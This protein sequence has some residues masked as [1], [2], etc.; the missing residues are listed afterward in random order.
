MKSRGLTDG[1][2][3]DILHS[4]ETDSMD[5][6]RTR[7]DTEERI[8]LHRGFWERRRL[9]HPPASFK[10]GDFFFARHYS[11]ARPLLV[12]NRPVEPDMLR[13][14]A[15]LPD[16]E[17]MYREVER[18][19]QDGF[20][21]AEPY[22]G[23]PWMEAVLGCPIIAGE[24]SFTSKPI[25]DDPREAEAA[26]RFDPENPWL[27][28]YL[29][30][31]RALVDLSGGRFPV[32]QPIMRGPTDM[33]GALLGQTGMI[34]ALADD[35]EGTRRLIRRV[36]EIFLAVIAEQKKIVP[37]FLGGS[38]IG[39]YHVWTP[40]TA[41]WFQDDL[42]AILSPDLYREY[43]LD[44]A[45]LIC[46]DY[47]FTAVHLHPSSFFIVDDLLGLDRLGAIQVNKDVGGP[48]VEE[49]LPTLGRI[50]ERKRLIFW[51]DLDLDELAL[52][53]DRLPNRGLFLQIVAR[54]FEDAEERLEYLRTWGS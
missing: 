52:V 7:P 47:D 10:V 45:R 26:L 20:W 24:E 31:T 27:R 4:M 54:T 53:R 16:Y 39:F 22:T 48:S 5:G 33:V 44:S 38:A 18:L 36:T 23:I 32:G 9:D 8:L 49:M 40:G 37:P 21:T 43:F 25:F 2:R 41:I 15:F 28:K 46:R 12:A 1:P 17:R 3:E 14:D 34:F 30:F 51:G 29:E 19:G 50:L 13:V 6:K 35:P 42:S 11:A